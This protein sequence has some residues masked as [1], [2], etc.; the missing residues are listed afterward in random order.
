MPEGGLTSASSSHC[1]P[2]KT[3]GRDSYLNEQESNAVLGD[4]GS[5]LD[6]PVPGGTICQSDRDRRRMEGEFPDEQGFPL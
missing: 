1:L 5:D 6:E 3:A 4:S 2:D